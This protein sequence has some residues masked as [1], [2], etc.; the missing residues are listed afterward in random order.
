MNPEDCW[1]CEGKK[2][3]AQY[4]FTFRCPMCGGTGLQ[5]DADAMSASAKS[6]SKKG[7]LS[8]SVLLKRSE[9]VGN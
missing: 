5:V 1:Y 8:V 7:G 2:I 6:E 3:I 4:A 9:H